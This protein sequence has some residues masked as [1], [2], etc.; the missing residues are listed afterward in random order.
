MELE[1]GVKRK[2]I[3]EWV[4]QSSDDDPQDRRSRQQR[5]RHMTLRRIGEEGLSRG[6]SR[7]WAQRTVAQYAKYL[8]YTAY[9]SIVFLCVVVVL[10]C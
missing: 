9:S 10:W 5:C 2:K 4:H 3:R 8:V 6:K 7:C 1:K